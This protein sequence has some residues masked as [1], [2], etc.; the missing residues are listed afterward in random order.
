MTFLQLLSVYLARKSRMQSPQVPHTFDVKEY[1]ILW[2]RITREWFD[3][4]PNADDNVVADP[5]FRPSVVSRYITSPLMVCAD[6]PPCG[7]LLSSLS[8]AP[9]KN[10]HRETFPAQVRINLLVLR[11]IIV[12]MAAT[13]TT[14]TGSSRRGMRRCC[15]VHQRSRTT[16]VLLAQLFAAL[17]LLLMASSDISGA[18]AFV[19]SSSSSSSRAA[20]A[21]ASRSDRRSAQTT[22]TTS[23][24][25][26]GVRELRYSANRDE[27]SDNSGEDVSVT[28]LTTDDETATTTANP[29][30][31]TT[32][33]METRSAGSASGSSKWD[34]LNPKIKER[35]V[36]AGQE[37][38]IANKK[39]REPDTDKKRR[40]YTHVLY[41]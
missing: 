11:S 8:Q 24:A 14:T 12:R 34:S 35:I 23:P 3:N 36:R 16:V 18:F 20:A 25:D 30:S 28:W 29:Q 5:R 22:A 27:D 19:S 4:Q 39:K 9:H 1:K 32:T 33:T 6:P 37:R 7:V 15:T 17:L 41:D 10:H 40:T 31:T 38:A 2:S 26:A 21:S 13:T